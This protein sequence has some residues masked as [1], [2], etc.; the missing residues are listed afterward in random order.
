MRNDHH[1]QNSNELL[2]IIIIETASSGNYLVMKIVLNK[3]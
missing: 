1:N 3:L 2:C